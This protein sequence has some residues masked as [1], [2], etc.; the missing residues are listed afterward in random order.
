M[1]IKLTT[2]A[3]LALVSVS[4]LICSGEASEPYW[5]NPVDQQLDDNTLQAINNNMI[6]NEFYSYFLMNYK[7]LFGDSN[8]GERS[9]RASRVKKISEIYQRSPLEWVELWGLSPEE[10]GKQ[11]PLLQAAWSGD[12]SYSSFLNKF[13]RLIPNRQLPYYFDNAVP[14]L[15]ILLNDLVPG[16][17]EGDIRYAINEKGFEILFQHLLPQVLAVL[18]QRERN[19]EFRELVDSL[20]VW[21]G[22]MSVEVQNRIST[23]SWYQK[24]I[25]SATIINE[26][27]GDLAKKETTDHISQNYPGDAYN[28]ADQCIGSKYHVQVLHIH[29]SER[30]LAKRCNYEKYG[31]NIDLL[32]PRYS[33][34]RLQVPTVKKREK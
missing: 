9:S 20:F 23:E 27:M 26:R 19:Q 16:I 5:R 28:D 18:A 22:E 24:L 17:K 10:R 32:R 25:F 2:L 12:E 15:Q 11:F 33:H 21:Y 6:G 34:D 1:V 14:Q 4:M 29:R 13:L 31:Y 8:E 3:T 7:T 30:S